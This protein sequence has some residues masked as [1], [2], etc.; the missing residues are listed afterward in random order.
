MKKL[1][2]SL[3]TIINTIIYSHPHVFFETNFLLHLNKENYIII[4][5]YLDESNTLI[6]SSDN[7]IKNINDIKENEIDFIKEIKNHFRIKHNNN[8]EKGK[9]I[10]ENA[11]IKDNQL[12]I[13]LK[14]IL[15]K[16]INKNDQIKFSIYDNNY[17]YTYDYDKYSLQIDSQ[18]LI[19]KI[20]LKEN[21]NEAYYFNMIYPL[22]YE[23]NFN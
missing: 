3:F 16:K 9:L 5:L 23:V 4:N 18:D 13:K 7:K 2:I 14:Y 17:Y 15:K 20:N 8:L 22:E 1:L 11:F 21:K 19:T 6:F 10:F 12:N